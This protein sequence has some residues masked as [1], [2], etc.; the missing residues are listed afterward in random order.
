MVQEIGSEFWISDQN[1][2]QQF[3]F[4]DWLKFNK[5]QQL[6]SL[7]RGAISLLLDSIDKQVK[8][9]K[10]LLPSFICDSV[11][12][13]FI[14]KGYNCVF[15]PINN[16]LEPVFDSLKDKHLWGVDVFFHLGYF[17]FATN[18]H[19]APFA[20]K[21]KKQGVIVVEDLSHSLFF[22]GGRLNC[23]DYCLGSIRKWA[24]MPSGG[25][26]ASEQPITL[27]SPL[28]NNNTYVRLQKQ[29]LLLKN[30]FFKTNKPKVKHEYLK[31][32]RSAQKLMDNDCKTYN[33]DDLSKAIINS[34]NVE[35]LKVKRQNNFLTLLRGISGYC[36]I[37]PVFKTLP[38]NVVPLFF[39]VYCHT[40][41]TKL[42]SFL[43]DHQIYCPIHW[44]VP[45]S[46]EADKQLF[47]KKVYN[48]I[49]SIPCDQRYD[50]ADMLRIVETLKAYRSK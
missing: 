2:P 33:I 11:L 35:T 41:R 15:Y 45:E 18:K 44:P 28:S 8:S 4:P 22:E 19:I 38:G 1:L 21:L 36:Q 32:F 29:A 39:P 24:G 30:S 9:K 14:K 6:T 5:H 7:G 50:E 34:L 47:S 31:L 43:I 25:F 3:I 17:G 12:D 37:E 20:Q 49:L 26:L 40:D 16:I 23:N 27:N 10:A 13:P 48:S 42:R 46:I